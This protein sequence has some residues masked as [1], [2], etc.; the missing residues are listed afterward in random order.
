MEEPETET[1][2]TEVEAAA[3][4]ADSGVESEPVRM[5][6][7]PDDEPLVHG[8]DNGAETAARPEEERTTASSDPPTTAEP[9]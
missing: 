4:S 7:Q 8:S 2:A 6:P 5:D 9:G 3:V 1:A